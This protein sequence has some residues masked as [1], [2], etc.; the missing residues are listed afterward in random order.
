MSIWYPLIG[1]WRSWWDDGWM[2]IFF[3][4]SLSIVDFQGSNDF[5]WLIVSSTLKWSTRI[6]WNSLESID[7]MVDGHCCCPISLHCPLKSLMRLKKT[8][9]R[10]PLTIARWPFHF[11]WSPWILKFPSLIEKIGPNPK[12]ARLSLQIVQRSK[13]WRLRWSRRNPFSWMISED[14]ISGSSR[15]HLDMLTRSGE[16]KIFAVF[17]ESHCRFP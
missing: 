5:H 4:P 16:S 14:S 1:Y 3:V 13:C 15:D 10:C 17:L 12:M 9:D 2:A 8:F 11:P 7:F 6:R